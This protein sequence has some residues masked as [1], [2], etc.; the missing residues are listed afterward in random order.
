[1]SDSTTTKKEIAKGFK[2]LML[3][4]RFDKITISDIAASCGINRQTFY[5]HFLDKYDLLDCIYY[6]EAIHY[7][8]DDLTLDNWSDK[9]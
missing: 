7:M 9:V 4:K 3:E 1:M 2:K 8:V 6:N 5:Y